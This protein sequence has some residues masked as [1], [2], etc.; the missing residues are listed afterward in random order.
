MADE[1]KTGAEE[2]G[3]PPLREVA[4]EQHRQYHP[5]DPYYQDK[6]AKADRK[7]EEK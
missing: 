4:E 2:M 5:S 7:S 6:P 1:E 3:R